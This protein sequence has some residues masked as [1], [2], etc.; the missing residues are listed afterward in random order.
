MYNIVN[1]FKHKQPFSV[2]NTDLVRNQGSMWVN[3][4]SNLITQIDMK[5]EYIMKS[6]NIEYNFIN[7]GKT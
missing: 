5:N 3:H 2:K 1:L 4:E 6:V 7:K